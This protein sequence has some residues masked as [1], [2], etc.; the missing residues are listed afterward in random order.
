MSCKQYFL[1]VALAACCF[2][3]SASDQTATDTSEFHKALTLTPN[4]DNGREIYRSCATCHGPEGWGRPGGEYPQIA[5]QLRNVIIKQLIDIREG[6]RG[7]PMMRPFT[8]TRTLQ[9]AQDIADVAEYI[10][11]L[12]MTNQN[13]TG[14]GFDPEHGRKLYQDNCTDCHG[15]RGE[16]DE[17][18]AIPLLYGQHFG[19]LVRQFHWIQVGR[20][21]NADKDMVEQIQGFHGRDITD[22]MDYVSRLSPPKEKLAR[23]GWT[24]PDFPH[25]DRGRFR[26]VNVEMPPTPEEQAFEEKTASGNE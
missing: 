16:G 24:N 23:P 8:D 22:V 9:S 25:F 14:P 4:A 26:Y 19:Y 18:K 7:N 2:S 13:E 21:K 20:R 17:K 6:N 5:G 1:I 15:D 11:K 10:A 3:V 12:P